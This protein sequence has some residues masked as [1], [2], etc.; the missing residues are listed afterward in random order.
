[1][2]FSND[3]A[4]NFLELK[5]TMAVLPGCCR[6]GTTAALT[7]VSAVGACLLPLS[8]LLDVTPFPALKDSKAGLTA[9]I[10]HNQPLCQLVHFL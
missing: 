3:V 5:I 1:M 7:K 8:V 9:G 10:Q 2:N 6:D 4:C